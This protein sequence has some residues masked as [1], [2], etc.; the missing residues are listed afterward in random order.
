MNLSKQVMDTLQDIERDTAI[1]AYG[2]MTEGVLRELRYADLDHMRDFILPLLQHNYELLTESFDLRKGMLNTEG[3][4]TCIKS[5]K[6][7]MQGVWDIYNLSK[8]EDIKEELFQELLD[9]LSES[10]KRLEGLKE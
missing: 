6:D 5:L 8:T 4:D 1:K 3:I 7:C 2:Q 9:T 10:V